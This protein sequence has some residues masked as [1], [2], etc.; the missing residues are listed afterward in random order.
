[1]ATPDQWWGRVGG[2]EPCRFPVGRSAN[3]HGSATPSWQVGAEIQTALQDEAKKL[4]AELSKED[5]SPAL[6]LR[7]STEPTRPSGGFFFGGGGTHEVGTQPG[8]QGIG[9]THKNT[10]RT[11]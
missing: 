2:R 4:E 1:M 10:P 8:T 11:L 3:L 5:T 7:R 9:G 6:N